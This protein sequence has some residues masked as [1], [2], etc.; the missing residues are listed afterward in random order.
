M[1]TRNDNS[2]IAK[3]WW[4]V[5]KWSLAILFVIMII[6]IFL[7]CSAS[8]AVAERVGK[9]PY[10]YL[11]KQLL[12]LPAALSLMMIVSFQSERMIRRWALI[13][14]I[15]ALV[16]TFM[17]LVNG[18]DAVKGAKRWIYLFGMSIQPSEFL[19]PTFC[20]L[21][22]YIMSES[23]Q[24]IQTNNKFLKQN[25][26]VLISGTILAIIDILLLLQ[27][28]IGMTFTI[29]FMWL[30]QAIVA[31]ISALLFVMLAIGGILF[32]ILLYFT[33]PHF[34]FRIDSFFDTSV[35]DNYQISQALSAFNSG[36][37]FGIGPGE[38]KVKAHIPDAHTDFIMAVAGEEFGFIFCMLIIL[39]FAFIVLRGF[40]LASKESKM[41]CLLAVSGLLVL[42]GFQA[43]INM[44][45]S[46][47]II[48][49]KGMTLP[50]ISYGGSSLISIALEM[51]FV[52]ALTR[53]QNLSGEQHKWL[54]RKK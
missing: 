11:K 51:G 50:F 21:S 41:F 46:L 15:V 37:I 9:E 10:A 35:G 26:G 38:G 12:F 31:G 3:W 42:F 27:P 6:G 18:A 13:G 47:N 34:R 48:P 30:A 52:L 16:M 20:I 19:K 33:F 17:T 44:S 39:L 23:K 45:S 53:R 25:S 29:S 1:F 49:T 32:L 24:L 36:G 40:L 8:P 7:N 43:I 4:S 22:A 54:I 28:D 14:F 5:D 2:V